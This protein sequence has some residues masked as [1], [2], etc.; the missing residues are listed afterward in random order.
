MCHMFRVRRDLF[1][2]SVSMALYHSFYRNTNLSTSAK[3][4]NV[5]FF[6][7]YFE[8]FYGI[9]RQVFTRKLKMHIKAGGC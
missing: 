4:E 9:S 3:H 7:R 1:S 6:L 5:G 8:L 2:K